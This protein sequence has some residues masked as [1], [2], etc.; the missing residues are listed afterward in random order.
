MTLLTGVRKKELV[1]GCTAWTLQ[2]LSLSKAVDGIVNVLWYIERHGI[3]RQR[4]TPVPPSFST[5]QG[6]VSDSIIE[7]T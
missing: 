5:F 1:G 4:G 2:R 7:K 6:N 3:L